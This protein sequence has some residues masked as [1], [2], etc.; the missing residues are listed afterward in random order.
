MDEAFSPNR[1]YDRIQPQWQAKLQ[2]RGLECEILAHG[3]VSHFPIIDRESAVTN[4]NERSTYSGDLL[5]IWSGALANP[6][7]WWPTL[8]AQIDEKG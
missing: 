4:F 2:S 5:Q 1:R 6:P 7:R 8:G 3:E